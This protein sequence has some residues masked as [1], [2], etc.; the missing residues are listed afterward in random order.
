M[1]VR[2]FINS[3]SGAVSALGAEHVAARIVADCAEAGLECRTAIG[4]AGAFADFAESAKAAPDA[5]IIAVAG[6]DGTLAMAAGEFLYHPK[7]LLLLPGGTM[8]LVAHDLG[9]CADLERATHDIARMQP[10][11]IDVATVNGRA[12]LN[13][14]V[15]GEFANVAEAREDVRAASDIEE[16]ID[17]IKDVTSTLLHAEPERFHV[18][19]PGGERDVR[20]N[21]LMIAN[22]AYTH[23]VDMRPRRTRLDAGALSIYLTDS[24]DGI[25]LIGRLVEMLRGD[26]DRSPMTDRIDAPSCVVT[27]DGPLHLTI[28]GEPTELPSPATVQIHPR[29]LTVLCGDGAL[30]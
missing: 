29:A 1:T 16:R 2:V 20:S 28:D 19:W 11:R 25:A 10:R 30:S 27:G 4:D 6:G 8:N 5:S 26:I 18:S 15:F 14:I 3:G 7:P 21:V 17:A 13:N 23:A 9:Q 12:F 22:N 24:G